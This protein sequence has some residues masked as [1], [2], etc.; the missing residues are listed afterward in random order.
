MVEAGS[1]DGWWR[2]VVEM[3]GGGRRVVEM[4]G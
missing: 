2:R 4:G 3:D 1:G